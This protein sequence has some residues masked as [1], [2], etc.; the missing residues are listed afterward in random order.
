MDLKRKL[1]APTPRKVRARLP[2][3]T[4]N[5]ETNTKMC[6]KTIRKIF[7]TLCCDEIED[8][9]WQHLLCASQDVLPFELLH[10]RVE[11]AKHFL[12]AASAQSW[13]SF[14]SID[15]CYSLLPRTVERQ[16]EQKVA[17]L[18]KQR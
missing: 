8:E 18:V 12:L 7:P 13:R 11:A 6:D 17:A 16:E 2:E 14:S 4:R 5:P 1:I 9:P 3:I 15:L 10:L